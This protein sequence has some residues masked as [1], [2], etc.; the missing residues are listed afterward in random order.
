MTSLR[1]QE[2]Q[3]TVLTAVFM[4]AILGITGVVLD[5]GSWFR[6]QRT[7]QATVDAAALAGAQALPF[8]AADARTQA[9]SYADKNGGVAGATI[10]FSSRFTPNDM[11]T[12]TQARDAEGVFSKLFGVTTV[13]LHAHASAVSEVPTAANGVAPIAVDIHHPQLSGPGCPCFGVQTDILLGKKGVPGAFGWIDLVAQNGNSG[14]STLVD[15]ILR[16]YQGYL[17]LGN[18]DSDP[19]AH[20]GVE[21][22]LQR[23]WGTDLLFPVYDSLDGTGSNAPYHVIGWAS[24]HLT[25]SSAQGN[26]ADLQGYFDRVIWDG[27]VSTTGQSNPAIPDLGVHSVALIN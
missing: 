18:Y 22:A 16:G 19:G 20:T 8:S 12:V 6:Q 9:T 27:I 5:V 2:G 11:I 23:R 26:T 24:F 15:W 4:I 17:P 14:S 10:T 13:T 1:R 7:Q 21:T 3:V 25:W